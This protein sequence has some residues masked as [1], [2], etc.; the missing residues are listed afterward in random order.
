[1]SAYVKIP[2]GSWH[3]TLTF[4]RTGSVLTRCGRLVPGPKH[5][6]DDQLPLNEKSCESCLRLEAH[7][8]VAIANDTVAG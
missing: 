5:T 7:D 2:R 8:K 6:V 4:T 1:M 3:A